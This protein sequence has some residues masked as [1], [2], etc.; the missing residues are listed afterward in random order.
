MIL[1]ID[2]GNSNIGLAIANSDSQLIANFRI[3]TDSTISYDEYYLVIDSLIKDYVINK[4]AIC[5]VVPRL[6]TTF[7]KIAEKYYSLTAFVVNPG[8]KTGLNIKTQ[9]QSEIGSDLI[10]DLCGLDDLVSPS[11]VVDLGTANKFLYIKN[12]SFLGAI[13]TPGVDISI[14][15]LVT[16]TALLPEIDVKVPLFALGT[17]T[18][19]CMQSGV[20][21]GT[22]AQ[23]DG[24]IERIKLE[25]K[26]SNLKIIVTGGLSS[27][28]TPLIM[29]TCTRD[30]MLVFKGL[31][32]IFL[33]NEVTSY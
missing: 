13:I 33:K 4:I 17:S 29:N 19:L 30:K 16:S 23:I 20:T 3:K 15:A 7:I 22:A 18:T 24:L 6:T 2:I 25:V 12:K 26:E 5:S 9:N 27:I 1:L 10:C 8:V 11:L 31:L 21:F 32:R 28:I 14:K